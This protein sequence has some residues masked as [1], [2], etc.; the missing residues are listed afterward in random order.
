MK[1]VHAAI[2]IAVVIVILWFTQRMER[3]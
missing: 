2:L 3:D 1:H